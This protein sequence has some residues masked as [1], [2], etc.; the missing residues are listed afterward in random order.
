MPPGGPALSAAILITAIGG[1][2][3]ADR[4]EWR[5]G[6]QGV[7]G[8]ATVRS[9]DI[10]ATALTFGGRVRFGYGL[11]DPIEVAVAVGYVHADALKYPGFM[12]GQQKGTLYP[13]FDAI[14]ASVEVRWTLGVEI[15]RW[16]DRT[17]PFF[18]LRGGGLLALVHDQDLAND[19]EMVIERLD[20][21]IDVRPFVGASVGVQH[22]FGDRITIAVLGDVALSTD[23]RHIGASVELDWSWY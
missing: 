21:A 18:A 7:L 17:Q 1:S 15:T 14:D 5:I 19:K 4:N 2:A 22:R 8:S 9:S 11:L 16:F 10:D 23:Y 3:R 6:A 20:D 13:N 12:H